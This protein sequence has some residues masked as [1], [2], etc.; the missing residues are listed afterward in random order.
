MAQSE[1]DM[2]VLRE[3]LGVFDLINALRET[4]QTFT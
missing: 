4:S 2:P 1:S 3:G